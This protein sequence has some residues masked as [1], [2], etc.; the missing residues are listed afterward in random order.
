MIFLKTKI[1]IRHSG[2]LQNVLGIC[3]AIA[4]C[5]VPSRVHATVVS[6]VLQDVQADPGSTVER[7][8][9]LTNDSQVNSKY[10]IFAE[11]FIP[12]GEEG[13][14]QYVSTSSKSDLAS[15]FEWTRSTFD[16][17]PNEKIRIPIR[18]SVPKNA[19]AGGHF[20]TVFFSKMNSYQTGS[21]VGMNEQIGVLFLVRVSGEITERASVEMMELHSATHRFNRLPV[22][23]DLRIRNE[24][25][26]HL[27]PRGTIIIKN[28]IGNTV[29]LIPANP[30]EGYVLP[31]SVRHFTTAWQ[32]ETPNRESGFWS[33][34]RAE[35]NQFAIGKY[36]A[37]LHMT[38]GSRS[39][40]FPNERIVFWVFPWH[41]A[42][43]ALIG[44]IV[45]LTGMLFYKRWLVKSLISKADAR[46]QAKRGH[47]SGD[48]GSLHA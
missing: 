26:V 23:F 24:G 35:W 42:V 29:A 32:K 4:I 13:G 3:F 28:A 40:A 10:S 43:C 27:Q 18:I 1:D 33:E 25:S 48:G 12:L 31:N 21:S 19:E 9:E 5:F 47:S 14:Q 8:I 20:A 15:W 11:D 7:V 6:P 44:L 22:E 17:K 34:T 30:K 41:L 2:F 36:V 45:V 16:L 38:Y 37:E 46:R 39:T